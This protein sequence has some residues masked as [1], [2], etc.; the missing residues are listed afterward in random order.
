L[1]EAGGRVIG[2]LLK[3]RGPRDKGCRGGKSGW[4]E[5]GGEGSTDGIKRTSSR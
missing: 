3:G 1:G 5:E 4:E 2:V